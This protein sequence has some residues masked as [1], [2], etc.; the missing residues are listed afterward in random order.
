M[1]NNT[2]IKACNIIKKFGDF[3]ALNDL[4]VRV[5]K[6][7]VFG[8]IGKN[9]AGKTTLMR[10]LCGLMQPDSGTVELNGRINFLPQQV[11]F[12]ENMNAVD[13]LRFFADLRNCESSANEKFANEL[14]I[15]LSQ[16]VR[17]LSPGQQ[18]K[19]QL[20]ISTIGSPDILILDEP[21]AGLDPSGAQQVRGIIKEL[22]QRGCTVFISSHVLIELEN[23][24]HDIAVIEK[25]EI[26]YQGN[27]NSFYE[28]ETENMGDEMVRS[29]SE[30]QKKPFELQGDL[31]IAEI[32]RDQVP[33]VLQFLYEKDIKVFGVRRQ[34]I[35]TLYNRLIKEVS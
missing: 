1:N 13:M 6:G 7:E 32:E 23:L 24:C 11:R 4:S 21:T 33:L 35:E 26:L 3:S 15:D 8:F 5:P 28:I 2:A 10:I 34:G 12:K 16:K 20:I 27:C 30:A 31:L 29:L 17:D 25:G 22:N 14:E 19:L 9:G 18:R